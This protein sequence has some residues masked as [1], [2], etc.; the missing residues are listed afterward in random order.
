MP[1]CTASNAT[2][3]I[4]TRKAGLLSAMGHDIHLK[5]GRFTLTTDPAS[6]T[7]HAS[8]DPTSIA[9]VSAMSNGVDTPKALSAK[10]HKTIEKYVQKDILHTAR[11]SEITFTSTAVT[12]GETEWT[13]RGDLRLHGK[14]QSIQIVAKVTGEDVIAEWTL[15]QP[16]FGIRPF[17]AMFGALKVQPDIRIRICA[18]L[19]AHAGEDLSR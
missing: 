12:P 13:V 6:Q 4:F 9:V 16:D 8:F 15:H 5:V 7:L 2:A 11:H 3:Q 14:I 18:P 19:N 10:D 1:T 17:S